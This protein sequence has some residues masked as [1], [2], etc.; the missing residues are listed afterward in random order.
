MRQQ[1]VHAPVSGVAAV[2]EVDHHH[3]MLLAVAVAAANALL[4]ALGVPGQVVIDDERAKLQVDA[5]GAGLGG[6]HDFC[7]IAEVLDQC[8]AGVCG[9]RAGDAVGAGVALQP[10][11][12][13]LLRLGAGVAAVEQHGLARVRALLQQRQQVI[14]G[15]SGFGED[16]RFLAG[17]QF[18]QFGKGA[19]Q[20]LQQGLAFG[21]VGDGDGLVLKGAQLGDF[22]RHAGQLR[23]RGRRFWRAPFLFGFVKRFV[24]FVQGLR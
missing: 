15:T 7:A 21:V 6:N 19:A 4:D 23:G 1:F 8:G 16:Q 13:N 9:A 2:D 11:G 24:V 10:G 5:F 12:V 14:L 17:A 20:R 3:I 22:V 18:L